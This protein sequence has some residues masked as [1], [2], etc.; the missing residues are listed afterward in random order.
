MLPLIITIFSCL[1]VKSQFCCC[2]LNFNKASTVASQRIVLLTESR[3]FCSVKDT[4]LIYFCFCRRFSIYMEHQQPERQVYQALYSY[5]RFCIRKGNC[6]QYTHYF[7]HSD[8]TMMLIL[9]MFISCEL[10]EFVRFCTK[11]FHINVSPSLLH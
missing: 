5:I 9:L 3:R 11:I 2:F 1:P 4:L 10:T 6:S 8:K 7:V